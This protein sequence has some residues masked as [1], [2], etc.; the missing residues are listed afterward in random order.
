MI[1]LTKIDGSTIAINE[2]FIENIAESPDTII[3]LNSGRSC[4]VKE[5]IDEIVEK[6]ISF[7]QSCNRQ[8]KQTNCEN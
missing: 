4:I 2:N 5:S 6:T 8:S 7:V 3:M 1:K